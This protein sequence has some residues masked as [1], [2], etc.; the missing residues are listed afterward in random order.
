[1]VF[2]SILTVCEPSTADEIFSWLLGCHG[3]YYTNGGNSDHLDE[4][5]RVSWWKCFLGIVHGHQTVKVEKQD[6]FLV[7]YFP[8]LILRILCMRLWYAQ[9]LWFCFYK[10][11]IDEGFSFGKIL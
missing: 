10:I 8:Q 9:F 1:M 5:D 3:I 2:M 6:F 4:E 7:I 11:N